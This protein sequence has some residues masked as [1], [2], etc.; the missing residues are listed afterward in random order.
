MACATGL[1]SLTKAV[2]FYG[3]LSHLWRLVP[4]GV[5]QAIKF[6]ESLSHSS[7]QMPKSEVEGLIVFDSFFSPAT[8]CATT[9]APPCQRCDILWTWL[10]HVTIKAMSLAQDMTPHCAKKTR[11]W[12][13]HNLGQ[14]FRFECHSWRAHLLQGK[15]SIALVRGSIGILPWFDVKMLQVVLYLIK[16]ESVWKSCIYGLNKL[17]LNVNLTQMIR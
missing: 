14:H 10:I 8:A 5:V 12:V 2:R 15:D 4:R 13:P 17:K 9:L 16:T 6:S 11:H 1:S 7:W 3:L